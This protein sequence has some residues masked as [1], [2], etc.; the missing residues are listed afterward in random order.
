MAP[1]PSSAHRHGLLV[2]G[3]I[4]T[5]MMAVLDDRAAPLY[6]RTTDEIT[7]THLDIASLRAMLREHADLSP[8]RLVFPAGRRLPEN[9]V[10]ALP[11]HPWLPQSHMNCGTCWP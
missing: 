10:C 5:E 7:L 9:P 3:S 11:A 6:N 1:F 4:H 2:L 8:E